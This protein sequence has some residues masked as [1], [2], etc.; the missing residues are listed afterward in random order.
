MGRAVKAPLAAIALA[1]GFVL[2]GSAEFS[3]E[4]EAGPAIGGI[5][6]GPALGCDYLDAPV[7]VHANQDGEDDHQCLHPKRMYP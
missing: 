2:A 6:A 4:G 1:F 5:E 7:A 3:G